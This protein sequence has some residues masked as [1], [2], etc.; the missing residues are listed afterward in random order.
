MT[1]PTPKRNPRSI[2]I[3]NSFMRL[4]NLNSLRKVIKKAILFLPSRLR[5]CYE[6]VID[7]FFLILE[8]C[9]H[10]FVWR[11]WLFFMPCNIM[12]SDRKRER[13]VLIRRSRVFSLIILVWTIAY[14]DMNMKFECTCVSYEPIKCTCIIIKWNQVRTS[15][16]NI[17]SPELCIICSLL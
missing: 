4:D 15:Q 3:K 17:A 11:F 13:F 10:A 2:S 16:L 8:Y 9:L 7:A 6:F 14:T 5:L 1:K 12:N